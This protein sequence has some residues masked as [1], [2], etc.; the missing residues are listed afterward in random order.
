MNI[1]RRSW[2]GCGRWA[3]RLLRPLLP[4]FRQSRR[5]RVSGVDHNPV[6]EMK[7]AAGLERDAA[8]LRLVARKRAHAERIRGKQSV[9]AHMP[10]RAPRVRRMV[11]N[12]DAQ[13][14][15]LNLAGVVAPVRRF[16]PDRLLVLLAL[17]VADRT[18]VPQLMAA[19]V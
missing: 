16:S 6:T 18:G 3:G 4:Q 11:E 9:G 1:A 8:V 10:A 17:G 7:R 13:L 15:A 14:L 19:A 2:S 12:R 5:P